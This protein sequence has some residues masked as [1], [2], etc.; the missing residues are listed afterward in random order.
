M[1]PLTCGAMPTKFARTVASSVCG[2]VSH[3]SSVTTTAMS[4]APTI[5]APTTRPTMRRESGSADLSPLVM[6]SASEDGHPQDEGDQEGQAPVDQRR[7]PDVGVDAGA[8]EESPGDQRDHDPDEPAQ[9]PGRK[10]GADDV[11]LRSHGRATP[12]RLAGRPR[13]RRR[14]AAP[15]RERGRRVEELEPR[16]EL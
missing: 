8:H 11:D 2:R 5:E 6:A 4:A 7:R 3:W 14:L 10:E 15:E 9:H 1:C 13:G 12:E 16:V